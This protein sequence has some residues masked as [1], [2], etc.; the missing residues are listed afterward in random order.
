M[1]PMVVMPSAAAAGNLPDRWDNPEVWL[2]PPSGH[3]IDLINPG[4]DCRASAH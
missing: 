3:A 1:V 4:T 2:A